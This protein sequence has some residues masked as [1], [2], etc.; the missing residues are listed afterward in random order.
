MPTPEMGVPGDEKVTVTKFGEAGKKGQD[1]SVSRT[2][3]YAPGGLVYHVL[4]QPQTEAELDALRH[5]VRRG[6]PFGNRAWALQTAKDLGL[7]STLRER[8]RPKKQR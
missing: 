6:G 1:L 3:R 7:E 4:N 2:A 8:G 5:C